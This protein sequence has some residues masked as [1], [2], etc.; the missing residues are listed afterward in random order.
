MNKGMIIGAVVVV[1]LIAV[2][3]YAT[4]PADTDDKMMAGENM[5]ADSMENDS[6]MKDESDNSM[7]QENSDGMMSDENADSMEA[8]NMMQKA[9]SYEVYA[10]EKLAL[11]DKGNVV[12]FFR[13]SW[14]PTCKALDADIRSHLDEIPADLTI[15]DVDYDK[16]TDLKKKYGVTYQHTFVQ[17]DS[18]GN[19]IKKWSGSPTLSA[20]VAEVS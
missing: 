20:L 12:L 19:V 14:C 8:D 16:H 3:I 1:A 18:N 15:L 6:M 5:G 9:G 4:K 7:M 17:V 10:P 11:A 2:G 13:A